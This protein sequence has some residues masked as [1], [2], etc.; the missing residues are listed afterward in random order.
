MKMNAAITPFV[1]QRDYDEP[2]SV[3][4]AFTEHAPVLLAKARKKLPEGDIVF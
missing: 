4:S 3:L 1:F 2:L